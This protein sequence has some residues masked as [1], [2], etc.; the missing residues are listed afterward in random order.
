LA[1][2]EVEEA[3]GGRVLSLLNSPLQGLASCLAE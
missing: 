2:L 3:L 1:R